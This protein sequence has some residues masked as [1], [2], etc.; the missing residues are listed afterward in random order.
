M[1]SGQER[2]NRA[3]IAIVMPTGFKTANDGRAIQSLIRSEIRL[4]V[5]F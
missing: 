3:V 1:G 5:A 4:S 2:A